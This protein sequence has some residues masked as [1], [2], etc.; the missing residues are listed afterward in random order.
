M[1]GEEVGRTATK[2]T[3]DGYEVPYWA[4]PP[5]AVTAENMDDV[6]IDLGFHLR[7]EVYLNVDK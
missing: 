4:L 3:Q 5:I 7:D 6:I 2:N 1:V